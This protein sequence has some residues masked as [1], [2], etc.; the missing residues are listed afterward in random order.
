MIWKVHLWYRLTVTTGSESRISAAARIGFLRQWRLILGLLF[1]VVLL[2]PVTGFAQTKINWDIPFTTPLPG[3]S[4]VPLQTLVDPAMQAELVKNL[5]RNPHWRQLIAEKKMAVGL[6]DLRDRAH[7]RFARVNGDE[8]MYAASLPKI[9]ILLASMD[10]LEKKQIP[11]SKEVLDDLRLMISHSDNEA[12]TRMIDRLTYERIEKVLCDPRYKLYDQAC[13]GGLWVGKRYASDGRRYPDPLKGL[14]HAASAT[15][16]CRF[17]YMLI[18]GKL[19]NYKRSKQ[20]LD[21]M[22]D[23]ALHHKFVN[24]LDQKTP[25]AKLFRK[26]GSWE[27]FHSD[28]ILVWGPR[29]RYILVGLIEDPDGEQILRDLVNVIEVVLHIPGA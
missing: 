25:Q 10:A 4:L 18:N 24:T 14:T 27:N 5:N 22:V 2:N 29:R 3:D 28:S 9:A 19:V 26:S 16:V 12:S 21:I 15:Q 7:L 1:C 13:G 20:M 17:Y 8:M 6:V 11:E 23:P